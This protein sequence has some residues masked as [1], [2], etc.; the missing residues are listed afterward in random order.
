MNPEPILLT[1]PDA[2]G[3]TIVLTAAVRD[4]AQ[5]YPGRYDIGVDTH[6]I[7]I[8]NGTPHVKL[9][10]PPH[11]RRVLDMRYGRRILA[12]ARAG[13][14]FLLDF[15]HILNDHLGTDVVLSEPRP[16]LYFTDDE[17]PRHAAVPDT[18]YWVIMP[19]WKG[20]MPVKRWSPALWQI[21]VDML[22]SYGIQCVQ[23]GGGAGPNPRLVGVTSLVGKT[24]LRDMLRIIRDSDGVI[25]GVTAAMHAAAGLARPC[26]VLAGGRETPTWFSYTND[27]AN[28]G[29]RASGAVQVPHRVLHAIGTLPCCQSGGCYKRGF[30]AAGRHH[31]RELCLLPRNADIQIAA[32]QA[33]ISPTQIVEAV[34]GYTTQSAQISAEICALLHGD[35]PDMHAR[36]LRQLL[37][38]TPPEQPIR[39]IA[40]AVTGASIPHVRAAAT[41]ARVRVVWSTENVPKYVWLGRL[42]CGRSGWTDTVRA[43][44]L[45]WLDDDSYCVRPGWLPDLLGRCRRD[46]GMV[47]P[48]HL[49][50]CNARW[51]RWLTASPWHARPYRQHPSKPVPAVRFCVGSVWALNTEAARRHG[52]PDARL[53]HTRGDITMGAQLYQAGYE[54]V[55]WPRARSWVEF[56]SAPRRGMR[57]T[58][59]ADIC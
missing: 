35:Y 9:R 48:L 23:L 12:S 31:A 22:A 27:A 3:D 18:P 10:P 15:V 29:P 56:N 52:V 24:S 25:C 40:N 16:A 51:L 44:W 19:G 53:A 57:G 7:D 41:D 55:N 45:V 49:W 39:L 42:L 14:H 5:Q 34:R 17:A 32:C 37:D 11:G 4:L 58:H 38:T 54:I 43:D 46:V 28:F 50:S 20:D 59:P 47:G 36:F 21:V 26:V 33:D 6:A 2:P 30:V 8:W 1:L 13:T